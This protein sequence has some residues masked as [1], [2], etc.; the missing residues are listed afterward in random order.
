MSSVWRTAGKCQAANIWPK[1]CAKSTANRDVVA[2]K[3][4]PMIRV[5]LLL[6]LASLGPLMVGCGCIA[7][8]KL[9]RR[10]LRFT[11]AE[12]IAAVVA[13]ALLAAIAAVW[14]RLIWPS[15]G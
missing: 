1:S 4:G 14:F 13:S 12:L 15:A 10:G 7:I 8:V 9:R 5:G 11:L 3:G 6:F 2:A